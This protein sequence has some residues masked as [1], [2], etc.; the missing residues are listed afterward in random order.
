MKSSQNVVKRSVAALT[1]T[2]LV[3]ACGGG[4]ESSD[5]TE[6]TRNSA[7]WTATSTPSKMVVY[8]T[9]D[10]LVQF[11]DL[12]PSSMSVSPSTI[13]EV[14]PS[15]LR[16]NGVVSVAVDTASSEV[17]YAGMDKSGSGYIY[18][19]DLDGN[20]NEVFTEPNLFV[21]G[22]GYD[23]ASRSA[24]LSFDNGSANNYILH[25]IDEVNSP[26]FES[27]ISFVMAPSYDGKNFV[28]ATGD[29]LRNIDFIN[30]SLVNASTDTVVSPSDVWS[31]A[32]DTQSSLY[33]GARQQDGQIVTM[34]M[35][36]ATPISKAATATN[37]ASLAVFSDGT[38]IVGTGQEPVS[39]KGVVG[40]ITVV[41]PTGAAAPV[42]LKGTGSGALGTGVQSVWA[43]E[44]PIATA[45]PRTTLD[46]SG[47]LTCTD[48]GWREDLPLSRLSRSPISSMRQYTWFLAD[49]PIP[50]EEAETFVPTK[51]G[52]YSCAVTSAN[53]AGTGQ[54]EMSSVV[55][56]EEPD[57]ASSITTTTSTSTPASDSSSAPDATVSRPSTPA[58][59]PGTAESAPTE[60]PVVTIPAVS[61]GAPIAVV[62][63][64]L[65]STK[66]TFKG[67]TA[68][69]TFRKF[70][71]AKKYR[72]YV[73]GAT[74][75]NIVCKSAKTT[76]TCTTT[77]LKKGVNTF[78]AKALSTSGVTVALSTKTRLTK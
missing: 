21:Y 66:W 25:Q 2:A 34:D 33:Y 49:T 37:P 47:T 27:K 59:S 13:A 41:D 22:M 18:R 4:S 43:V 64:S 60:S 24:L 56:V 7:V 57:L 70:A 54:S 32:A 36:K 6:R 69:V 65:R 51:E 1:L 16:P 75:K 23:P 29:G 50:G 74:R 11:F 28:V 67:R 30:P 9:Q 52:K 46:S 26:V 58:E 44:S 63:P 38:I 78:S 62:T 12:L 5:T 14:T 53:M 17:V 45:P 15:S 68:K 72:L 77:G 42:T 8:G 76:V 10:G 19:T 73:R 61:P 35:T 20:S 40:A 39:T 55:V 31:F 48:A 71:G 3:A